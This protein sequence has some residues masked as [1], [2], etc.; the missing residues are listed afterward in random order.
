MDKLFDY[1]YIKFAIVFILHVFL[2]GCSD[3]NVSKKIQAA[4]ARE[5]HVKG[6]VV[7]DSLA[8]YFIKADAVVLEVNKKSYFNKGYHSTIPIILDVVDNK[9]PDEI[10]SRFST[11]RFNGWITY[12]VLDRIFRVDVDKVVC[13]YKEDYSKSAE[14][15]LYGTL[16]TGGRYSKVDVKHGDFGEMRFAFHNK[17]TSSFYNFKQI[18]IFFFQK[19]KTKKRIRKNVGDVSYLSSELADKLISLGSLKVMFSSNEHDISFYDDELGTYSLLNLNI[20]EDLMFNGEKIVS[21]EAVVW[22]EIAFWQKMKISIEG[23]VCKTSKGLACGANVGGEILRVDGSRLPRR[24][25]LGGARTDEILW[26]ANFPQE[27]YAVFDKKE[28]K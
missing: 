17:Q 9:L 19:Q 11:C 6:D 1:K 21:C 24:E 28:E 25:F 15:A 3:S 26:H 14:V 22:A 5:I 20:G 2:V 13:N 23:V 7:D 12:G 16:Y 10:N 18:L 27:M 8:K 4:R